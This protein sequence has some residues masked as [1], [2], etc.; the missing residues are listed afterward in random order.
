M[1]RMIRRTAAQNHDF[2]SGIYEPLLSREQRAIDQAPTR[3]ASVPAAVLECI[4]EFARTHNLP[5]GVA[6]WTVVRAG[7]AAL[8]SHRE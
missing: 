6:W 8:N 4:I 3:S 1:A 5:S 7:L 2:R